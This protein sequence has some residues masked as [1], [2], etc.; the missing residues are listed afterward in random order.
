MIYIEHPRVSNNSTHSR[1]SSVIKIDNTSVEVWFE[2][3]NKYGEYLCHERADAFIVGLLSFAMRN[4]HDI[5]SLAPLSEEILYQL[6][7]Y[8]IDTLVK[9]D[10]TLYRTKIT[11]PVD[12]TSLSSHNA[13]AT[14]ISCGVDSLHAVYKNI[15]TEYLKHNLTHL[16]FNNVGSHGEG[17]KAQILYEERKKH[18]ESFCQEYGF[19]F[20]ESNSNIMDAIPQEHLLTHT[21]SSCFA[22]LA[23]QKLYSFY[24]YASSNIYPRFSVMNNSQ[25]P[26]CYYELL[27][28]QAFSTKNLK[29]Y[30]EG[31][32]STRFDKTKEIVKYEPSYKYLNV[33]TRKNTNCGHCEKCIRT[34]LTLEALNKLDL[35]SNVFDIE[36]YN[37]NKNKHYAFMFC[38]YRL[39]KE[40]YLETY[41]CLRSK[42]QFTTKIK[43]TYLY[44]KKRIGSSIPKGKLKDFLKRISKND[45]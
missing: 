7:S 45:L 25:K 14:G 20:I 30:S 33:C 21:Y 24:Y 1:L 22:I 8:F 3:K 9:G 13:V 44:I 43:G 16:C 32:T 2:V 6:E 36:D 39:G 35:Y 37:K 40:A 4:G 10:A 18:A 11:A 5:Q 23:L 29:I 34:L 42:L 17:E 12:S 27:S 28:L 38:N 41:L 31:A 19:E 26:S 15:Q